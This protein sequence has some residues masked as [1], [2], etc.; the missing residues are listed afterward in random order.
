MKK[1]IGIFSLITGIILFILSILSIFLI[2]IIKEEKDYVF[3]VVLILV[4][5]LSSLLI[6]NFFNIFI[7]GEK[8]YFCDNNFLICKRKEKILY[9]VNKNEVTDIIEY[10]NNFSS[11]LHRIIFR[12]KN[13]KIIVYVTE[14]NENTVQTFLEG[15]SKKTKTD[16]WGLISVLFH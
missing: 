2:Y 9:N 3:L 14:E 10:K 1:M 13:R 16:I 12:Y 15:L 8:T 7:I 5:I 6:F 11:T 4:L